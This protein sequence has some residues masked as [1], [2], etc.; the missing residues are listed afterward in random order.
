MK[1]CPMAPQAAKP[2]TAF[3]T[4]GLR[5]IKAVASENSWAAAEVRPMIGAR[6]VEA[7]EGE[8]SM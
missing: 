5:R 8:R 4:E 1:I 3:P 7:R 2:R 6:G